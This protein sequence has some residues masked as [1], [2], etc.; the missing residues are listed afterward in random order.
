MATEKV[1]IAVRLSKE[2]LERLDVLAGEAGVS[3]NGMLERLIE[4]GAGAAGASSDPPRAAPRGKSAANV[5]PGDLRV[6]ERVRAWSD[7]VGLTPDA[8]LDSLREVAAPRPLAND[9][10]QRSPNAVRRGVRGF[11]ATDGE[12][13]AVEKGPAAFFKALV[14]GSNLGKKGPRG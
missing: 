6:L 2:Q 3:R 13:L 4:G 10:A 1:Q 14:T 8:L 7:E 12:P 9:Q 5:A 11:A